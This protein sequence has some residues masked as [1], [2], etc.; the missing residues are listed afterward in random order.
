MLQNYKMT[1]PVFN[2]DKKTKTTTKNSVFLYERKKQNN[3]DVLNQISDH[4]QNC[5]QTLAPIFLPLSFY[6][7]MG[8]YYKI[9]LPAKT[10]A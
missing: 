5:H 10:N 9:S 1:N 2:L 7:K 3:K 6:T 8:V 4:E